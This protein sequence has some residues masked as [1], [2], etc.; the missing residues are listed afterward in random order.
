MISL[1]VAAYLK[2]QSPLIQGTKMV[3]ISTPLDHMIQDKRPN[4][5]CPT[6]LG[7]IK[8]LPKI[9]HTWQL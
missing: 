8:S 5:L 6:R 7:Q 4:H 2:V 9:L 3:V 1:V